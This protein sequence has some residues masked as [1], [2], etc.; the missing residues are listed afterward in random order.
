MILA[1]CVWRPGV[2]SGNNWHV[3]SIFNQLSIYLAI[4]LS[5]NYHHCLFLLSLLCLHLSILSVFL[6]FLPSIPNYIF[7]SIY[8]LIYYSLIYHNCLFLFLSVTSLCST[9]NPFYQSNCLTVFLPINP[10]LYIY[11][12]YLSIHLSIKQLPIYH[13]LFILLSVTPLYSTVHLLC[14]PVLPHSI[15]NHLSIYLS[16]CLLIRHQFYHSISRSICQP[17]V[18]NC[19]SSLC[20]PVLRLSLCPRC[21]LPELP[22]FGE[23]QTVSSSR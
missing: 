2:V 6:S 16:I 15:L 13:R 18:F 17:F 5:T 20:L 14:L 10:Q 4:N 7:M 21:Q 11:S 19:H 3:S 9:V 22:K 8:L 12:I 1:C 23:G